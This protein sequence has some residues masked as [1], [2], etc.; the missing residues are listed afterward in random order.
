MLS[1]DGLFTYYVMPPFA[2]MTTIEA[3]TRFRVLNYFH[4][5]SKSHILKLLNQYSNPH[6]FWT[7]LK[8]HFEDDSG[9]RP[10]YFI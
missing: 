1:K 10:T 6:M 3:T 7:T 5:N 9:P 4:N 8:C 2:P